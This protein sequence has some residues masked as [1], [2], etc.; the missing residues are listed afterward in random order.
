MIIKQKDSKDYRNRKLLYE[1]YS[2]FY[3]DIVP[4][5]GNNGGSIKLERKPF[6]QSFH[7]RVEEDVFPEFLENPVIFSADLNEIEAGLIVVAN[8]WY[9]TI[10]IWNIN[11]FPE[12]RQRGVGSALIKKVTE[13]AKSR[14]ARRIVLETQSSNFPAIN[15]YLS[16]DFY[17]CGLD[18]T[19]YSN[20][21]IQKK[22]VRLEFCKCL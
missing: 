2:D 11:I 1:Y 12:F 9:K 3:F 10:R 8:E 19:C 16:H 22:E 18:T 13:Y 20:N 15:F 21:D 7:K 6:I 5:F 17:L 14:K 4:L